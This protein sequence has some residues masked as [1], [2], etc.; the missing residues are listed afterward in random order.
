[1]QKAC[2][3]NKLFLYFE[4]IEN[5]KGLNE[6]IRL[7]NSL[8]NS[9]R[10]KFEQVLEIVYDKHLNFHLSEATLKRLP[11]GR[12][13]G[14]DEV[15]FW[16]A[17]QKLQN[18]GLTRSE[19]LSL[20]SNLLKTAKNETECK[21]V[22]RIFA[23]NL[24]LGVGKEIFKRLFPALKVFEASPGRIGNLGVMLGFDLWQ[25]EKYI[26]RLL[27]THK[28]WSIEPKYDGLRCLCFVFLSKA[29]DDFV[30]E[31]YSRNGKRLPVAE[32]LL[33]ESVA[34]LTTRI[35]PTLRKQ[36]GFVLDGELFGKDWSTTMSAIFTRKTVDPEKLQKVDYY[37]FD[38]LSVEG[39]LKGD[40][41]PY[42]ERR[43]LLSK[44]LPRKTGKLIPVPYTLYRV[45]DSEDPVTHFLKFVK[46]KSQEAIKR[47]LEGVMA[48]AWD[49]TYTPSRSKLW[50]KVK[51]LKTVDVKVI[52]VEKHGKQEGEIRALIVDYKGKKVHVGSGLSKDLRRCLYN[53]PEDIIGMVVE[54][55]YQE[56]TPDGSL[57]FPRLLRIRWDKSPAKTFK[58]LDKVA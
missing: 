54:V 29:G 40:K 20:V 31:C 21:W 50:I 8:P 36:K 26:P 35:P 19:R 1:M 6:K 39:A 25:I 34:N 58:C 38:L 13:Q 7:I 49:A 9:C 37:V 55:A 27:Q 42:E 30:L 18:P 45:P 3:L 51:A 2:P 4:Q 47:G 17:V 44:V 11:C 46:A 41:R 48:K 28:T 10:R 15:L 33:L 43:K 24:K 23:K 53:H 57:R 14:V 32:G 5:A 56:E 16:E 52:G 12:G 22:K